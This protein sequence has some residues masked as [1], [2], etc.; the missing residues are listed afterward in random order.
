ME[1]KQMKK[2]GKS[3]LS[4]GIALLMLLSVM[5]TGIFG[6]FASAGE[7]YYDNSHGYQINAGETLVVEA[8]SREYS[9][10]L[11]KFTPKTTGYYSFYSE[12]ST[13]TYGYLL[14]MNN[15][16]FDELLS[17]DDGYYNANF[18]IYTELTAGETYYFGAAFYSDDGGD[19]TVGLSEYYDVPISSI[20]FVPVETKYVYDGVYDY[21]DDSFYFQ[22]SS[23]IA[24]GDRIDINYING[25]TKSY[26]YITE[27]DSGYFYGCGDLVE[28]EWNS[29]QYSNP[30][31]LSD[32]GMFE[33]RCEGLTTYVTVEVR[34]NPVASITYSPKTPFSFTETLSWGEWNEIWEYSEEA[35]EDIVV[36][37]YY[38]YDNI[39]PN[40]GDIFTV[41]YTNGNSESFT[42]L[43]DDS[44]E[45]YFFISN[46]TGKRLNNYSFYAE[47]NETVHFE[48]GGTHNYITFSYF[49]RSVQIPVEIKAYPIDYIEYIQSTPLV[50]YEEASDGYWKEVYDYD[51]DAVVGQFYYYYGVDAKPGDRITVHYKDGS[52]ERFI[53]RYND[54]GDYYWLSKTTGEI[55]WDGCVNS[56]QTFDRQ[57]CVGGDYNYF[58]YRFMGA[59]V[60]VP[61]QVLPNP[62]A[63]I[64][65]SLPENR[66]LIAF[67]PGVYDEDADYYYVN[68][69]VYNNGA[70]ITVNLVNGETEVFTY[71]GEEF[72]DNSGNPIPYKY[73]FGFVTDDDISRYLYEVGPGE[74]EIRLS[75]F[76]KQTTIPLTVKR[77]SQITSNLAS[78]SMP[79]DGTVLYYVSRSGANFTVEYLDG[80]S[81]VWS[82]LT[83]TTDLVSSAGYLHPYR[84]GTEDSNEAY[85]GIIYFYIFSNFISFTR[86]PYYGS[87]VSK[88]KYT[89]VE[90]LNA[91]IGISPGYFED[92]NYYFNNSCFRKVGDTLTVTYTD[93]TSKSFVYKYNAFNYSNGYVAN[94][95]E[96]IF[97]EEVEINASQPFEADDINVVGFR[98]AGKNSNVQITVNEDPT[99]SV[100]YVPFNSNAVE[101]HTGG[102][103]DDA[104]IWDEELG[105]WKYINYY[106]YYFTDFYGQPGDQIVVTYKDGSVET[107]TSDSDSVFHSDL[108]ENVLE[109]TD[110]YSNQSNNNWTVGSEHN[111]FYIE[112]LNR[113]IE[114]P[115]II[116]PSGHEHTYDEGIVTKTPTA[117][118]TGIMRYTCTECGAIKSEILPT[119]EALSASNI[120]LYSASVEY[121]GS[122][123]NP[124]VTVKNEA[125]QKL[126]EGTDYTVTVPEGRKFPGTYVYTVTGKGNYGGSV[127]KEFVIKPY[128]V[129]ASDITLYSET[130]TYNGK[131]RTPSITVKTPWGATLTEGTHYTV[132]IP[133][134][135]KEPGTYTYTFTFK[136]RFTGTVNKDF[137]I[138]GPIESS[139]VT[140]YAASV[141]YNGS[142]RNPVVTVK[143]ASGQ[144]LVEGTDYT[145]TVPEGRK[146]PG[147]YTYT[148]TGIGNYTGTVNKDFVIKPYTVKASDITLYSEK[149]TYNGKVRTPTITVKTPWGATLT[150]G[151]H[152]TLQIPE[153]RKE[154]GT[155]TY[156]FTFKGRFTG[157]VN[158]VF[159]I[160]EALFASNI[161]VYAETVEYNGSVRNPVVTVKNAAGKKLVEGTDYTLTVPEGRKFPGTYTYTVKGQGLYSG[162]IDK[163]FVIKP[164]TVKASDI[165]LYSETVTYNGKVR[166]P[167][168]TV[169]TP[170]GATLTQGTHYSVVVPSGRKDVGTYTYKF[171]F[172]GNFT[173]TVNKV[174]TIQEA[175]STANIT[176][177]AESV[178]YNGSVRNPVV[179]VKNAAGKKLVEGTDYTLTVPEGRKFPGTYT[180]A[181]TG[182]GLYSGTAYKD[183]VIKPYTVKASDITLYSE[184]VTYNGKVR[185][186]SITVKTPWGATLTEGTHY[187][188][189]IP[190]G[191]KDVGTYTYTLTFKGNF[192]GTVN[193]VFTIQEALSASNITVYAESVEYNGSV[194]NPVVTVK[195]S[196]GKKLVEG[197][198]YTV[199]V[200]EGRKF[201]GTYTY[202]VKG[203]GLYSGEVDKNFVIR[204]YTVKASDI[205]LYSETVTYNGKVRTPTITVKT[206]WGATLTEG[207]H[208]TV[209]IPEGRKDVGTYTYKFT[210][211]GNF[212][213]T[214]NK[215]FTITAS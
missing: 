55:V 50:L 82:F 40:I 155:Y 165:T 18:R 37:E 188:V 212:T 193:K 124:V 166:T 181:V 154:V 189:K 24:V 21:P 35:G 123:R 89:P 84:N 75:V 125:G 152:Y 131:V 44:Y 70:T 60:D 16:G 128:T 143:N 94:D 116:Y 136:G 146:F 26:I 51:E 109:I 88:I 41:R 169:K 8:R 102:Y 121:N 10:T 157:T 162:E 111:C 17:N 183:F 179:T 39:G 46:L 64:S 203:Q 135:R 139:N 108:T 182:T 22:H 115:V 38:Y 208:Y 137:T 83:G 96:I 2:S 65:Y 173:G 6:L 184:T 175:L 110:H 215:V 103:W 86:D 186:P 9:I 191:R 43:Y 122:V 54:E 138:K 31:T 211:K 90:S 210:F 92:G 170:W 99:S 130:V 142:V 1:E 149:V 118:E 176:V 53:Y 29:Y 201:P 198:D 78:I 106:Y 207:T 119:L 11:I 140:I 32:G 159:T 168:I 13:D 48:P 164:Y 87:S 185:T 156:T 206:P 42:Y 213:G 196:A 194:R 52:T 100:K 12:S 33:I 163:N 34:E 117:D 27:N 190:D 200:P 19:I 45:E 113:Y 171:T 167:T 57:I 202:T 36:G 23:P 5:P 187:T 72:V 14:K 158:K 107:F 132:Q 4:I 98:Y 141:E 85:S 180:Y 93:G 20:E 161:T 112:A 150:E 3:F 101:E 69:F 205:T 15:D 199:V 66:K 172:K 62:V 76:G 30:W 80:S 95:G 74:K 68:W 133:E 73:E 114:V 126:T 58:T 151:T 77:I 192:T 67:N 148:I 129:K 47:Q 56:S 209:V 177:Y 97:E 61:I 144:K 81:D 178:E 160:Q 147:T 28:V 134:G 49:G 63:S 197:T 120:T 71:N 174:F 214:V 195:N 25:K 127:N 79:E 153:G 145:L 91:T 204:P 105:D 59:N 104:D 7:D